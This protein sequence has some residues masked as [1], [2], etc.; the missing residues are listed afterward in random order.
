[1]FV[2]FDVF[3]VLLLGCF[4]MLDCIDI[5]LV[6]VMIKSI[7]SHLIMPSSLSQLVLFDLI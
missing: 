6:A 1:M 2:V 7:V 4:E 5:I 3:R